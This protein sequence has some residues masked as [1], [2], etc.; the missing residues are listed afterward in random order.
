MWHVRN[1]KVM[2][3][4]AH[5]D[6]DAFYILTIILHRVAALLTAEGI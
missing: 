3:S 5:T 2:F 6:S 4:S 1:L